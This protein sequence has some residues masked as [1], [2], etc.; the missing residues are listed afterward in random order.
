M[1]LFGSLDI[2]SLVRISRLN[3]VGHVNGMDNARKVVQ[4]FNIISQGTCLG[5]DLKQKV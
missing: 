2:F 1:Q 5:D 3:W 4:V